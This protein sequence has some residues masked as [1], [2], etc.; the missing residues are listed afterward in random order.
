MALGAETLFLEVA[1]DNVAA[2]GLY[3]ALGFAETGRRKA[4]YA[5]A[6]GPAADALILRVDLP[7]SA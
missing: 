6:G 7:L 5:R 4:Y 1:V 2:L 3:T